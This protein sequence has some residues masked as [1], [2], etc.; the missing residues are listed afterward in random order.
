MFDTLLHHKKR[1]IAIGAA[2]Q[3]DFAGRIPFGQ[4]LAL[5]GCVMPPPGES[6]GVLNGV[7]L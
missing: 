2:G 6:F 5:E 4:H 1:R 3:D 7:H